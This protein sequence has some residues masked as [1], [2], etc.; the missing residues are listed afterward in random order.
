MLGRL[1]QEVFI[2]GGVAAEGRAEHIIAMIGIAADQEFRLWVLLHASEHDR[3]IG[4]VRDI[5]ERQVEGRRIIIGDSPYMN[6]D[7]VRKIDAVETRQYLRNLIG[8]GER[9]YVSAVLRHEIL[10]KYAVPDQNLAPV[11]RD[12]VVGKEYG[13]GLDVDIVLS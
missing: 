3:I 2:D 7:D 8:L 10:V 6:S 12:A 5:V 1:W 11:D 13:V 4:L 9:I